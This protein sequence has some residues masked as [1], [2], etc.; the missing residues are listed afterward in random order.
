MTVLTGYNNN[1]YRVDDIDFSVNPQTTFQKKGEEISY[2]DYYQQRYGI[3]IQNPTQPLLL[4]RSTV[5]DRRA[6]KDELVYLIPELCRAT[7]NLIF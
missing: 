5:R 7:G 4:S 1:T 6:G 3:R 2:M